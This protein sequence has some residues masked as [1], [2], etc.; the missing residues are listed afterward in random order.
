MRRRA[1]RRHIVVWSQSVG[2]ADR[3]GAA[4]PA[5]AI[6]TGKVRR[7]IRLGVLLAVV[8]LMRLARS[9]R[10][11]WR[12]F[13]AGV[14]LVVAGIMLPSGPW[15]ALLLAGFWCLLRALLIPDSP[16]ADRQQR[17]ELIPS[18]VTSPPSAPRLP[19]TAGAPPDQVSNAP[20][21]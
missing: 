20:L 17:G 6:R 18:Y 9:E 12:P 2:P 4:R 11:R 19:E 5:A 8:G 13:L 16:D 1:R 3:Y 15:S 7:C 10:A 14:V 21:S